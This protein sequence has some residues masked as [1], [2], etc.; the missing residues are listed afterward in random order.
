M[1][2]M[3]MMMMMIMTPMKLVNSA[4]KFRH[5]MDKFYQPN[6]GGAQFQK[7]G[8]GY[9]YTSYRSICLSVDLSIDPSYPILSHPI[10]SHPILIDRTSYRIYCKQSL[11]IKCHT[12][13]ISLPY[14]YHAQDATIPDLAALRTTVAQK[15]LEQVGMATQREVKGVGYRRGQKKGEFKQP[16]KLEIWQSTFQYVGAK[17]PRVLG[18]LTKLSARLLLFWLLLLFWV[19]I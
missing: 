6:S 13:T 19:F 2:M 5:G 9:M 12:N 18:W 4:T 16:S 1:M 10:L 7:P 11:H 3:M 15:V 8:R 17:S 14:F